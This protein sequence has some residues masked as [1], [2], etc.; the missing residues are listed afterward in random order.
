MSKNGLNKLTQAVIPLTYIS[1]LLS[2]DF[3]L[4]NGF[5][6]IFHEFP[7][8]VQVNSGIVFDIQVTMHHDKFL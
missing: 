1:G 5:P 8:Y 4:D 3:G 6:D 7:Q 2:S